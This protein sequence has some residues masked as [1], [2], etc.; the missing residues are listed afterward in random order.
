MKTDYEK[1]IIR[2]TSISYQQMKKP[3]VRE[4]VLERGTD[5]VSTYELIMLI[6]GTGTQKSPV[7]VLAKKVLSCIHQN[8]HKNLIESLQSIE[9]M[10]SA[11]SIIIAAAVEL[12]KRLNAHN[13]VRISQPRDIIPMVQHYALEQQEH[14]LCVLLNGAHVI[15]KIQ[16]VSIGTLNHTIIHPRE[17]FA[18]AIQERSAAVIICHNHPSGQKEPSNEDIKVTERLLQASRILGITLL[19]HIIL[20]R[21]AFFS[22][23][24]EN[25]FSL[26]KELS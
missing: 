25:L 5:C 22:F 21:N 16:V 6:L 12:G 24:E 4:S 9:G 18:S 15:Q 10:G 19:D 3:N 14:F 1:N 2:E 7:E 8:Q 26:L 17:I 20:T 23:A 13:E 11:K